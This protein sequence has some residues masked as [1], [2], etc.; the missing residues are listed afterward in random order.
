MAKSSPLLALTAFTT[1]CVITAC[2]QPAKNSVT[3]SEGLTTQTV[4][5]A[6]IQGVV[7]QPVAN[8]TDSSGAAVNYDQPGDRDVTVNAPFSATRVDRDTGSVHVDAPFVHIDKAGRGQKMHI[9]IGG[10]GADDKS[11]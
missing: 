9:D 5:P 4:A 2:G 3:T 6:P 7:A 11:R 1:I 8:A 10:D